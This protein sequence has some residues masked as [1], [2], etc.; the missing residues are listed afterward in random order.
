VHRSYGATLA[1]RDGDRGLI[2]VCHAGCSRAHILAE[3]R[4]RGLGGSGIPMT[5]RPD[6]REPTDDQARRIELARA[7]WSCARDA[8]GTP[9]ARYL[10]GRGITVEPPPS[11]RYA[12]AVRRMDGTCG[13]AMVARIDRIGG[14][15]IGVARTWLTRDVTGNWDR[16]DR[17]MLGRAA[18]G[19]VRLAPATET[20]MVGEGVETCLAVMQ[21]TAWPAWAALSTSG[22]VALTLPPIV[23]AVT[24]LADNDANGAGE[25]AART[26]AQR[27]LIE[28]RR[29][30]IATPPQPDTDFADLLLG[31]AMRDAA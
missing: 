10:A 20:L 4:W 28:G 22:M 26:A 11:L 19:A 3:L 2:T 18:G 25:R 24:I 14:E 15:M 13:A 5:A 9:V 7:I 17:A 8:R 23:R 30:R 6:P 21:A 12:P 16:L 27:W 31:G 1:L 29:V